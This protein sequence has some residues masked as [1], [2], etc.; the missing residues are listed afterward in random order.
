MNSVKIL[1]MNCITVCKFLFIC[2]L[3]SSS[4]E[5]VRQCRENKH[6]AVPYSCAMIY[7]TLIEVLI[8]AGS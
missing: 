4:P 8:F 2:V 3:R 7:I 6:A 5:P 1:L